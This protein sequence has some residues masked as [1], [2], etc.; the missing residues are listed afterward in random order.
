[1]SARRVAPAIF[2]IALLAASCGSDDADS[3][4]TDAPVATDVAPPTDAPAPAEPVTGPATIAADDQTGDGATVAVASVNLPTAG[5]VVIHAD[6]G[7][8]PGAILGWSDLLPAGDSTDVVVTLE[9]PIDASATVFPMAHVDANGNGEYEFMPPE[10]TIDVPATT[11]DGGVAVLPV[12]YEVAGSGEGAAGEEA[13][14]ALATSGFGDVLVDAAGNIVYLFTPD[15][16]GDSTCY[17][18]CADNW[19]FVAEASGVG[20]GLDASLLGTTTRTNGDV[21]ATYNGWPLYY[22]GGD[23]AP[24]DTNGQGVGDVWWVVDAAGGAVGL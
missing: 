5:F 4:T 24:G 20:A 2:A 16:Q 7:G 23:A 6:G 8:S 22:F 1:M 17:D 12:D 9:S 21:Q 18:Q 15:G 14:L 19:P 13:G 10:V 3:S 11:A